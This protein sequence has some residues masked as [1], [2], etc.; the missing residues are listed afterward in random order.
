MVLRPRQTPK[1]SR[2]QSRRSHSTKVKDSLC[3]GAPFESCALIGEHL[4]ATHCVSRAGRWERM[5]KWTAI[6][7]KQS[8]SLQKFFSMPFAGSRRRAGNL[9]VLMPE[10]RLQRD[11]LE[12]AAPILRIVSI[13][14]PEVRRLEQMDAMTSGLRR[15]EYVV[16]G[17]ITACGQDGVGGPARHRCRR[18]RTRG[19]RFQPRSAG[20]TSTPRFHLHQ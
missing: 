13:G 9:S 20:R 8:L 4:T 17:A 16:G 1:V 2:S 15:G 3:T 5:G 7:L 11:S 18:D 19:C 12:L 14:V 10:M 6:S